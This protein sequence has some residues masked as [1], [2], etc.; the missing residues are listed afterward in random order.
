MTTPAANPGA[1]PTSAR[2][3]GGTS[4]VPPRISP[5]FSV[6]AGVSAAAL[7]FSG[8]SATLLIVRPAWVTPQVSEA[9]FAASIAVVPTLLFG[10]V[11]S[12]IRPSLRGPRALHLGALVVGALGFLVLAVA[13]WSWITAL[14]AADTVHTFGAGGTGDVGQQSSLFA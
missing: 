9:I 5:S 3:P 8:A 12:L 4:E 11:L 13:G 7:V 10:A 14:Q 6:A 2:D 1:S